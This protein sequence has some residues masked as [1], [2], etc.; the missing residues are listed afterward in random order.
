[1]ALRSRFQKGTVGARKG[2]GMLRVNQTRPHCVN[3]MGNAQAKP[4]ATRHWQRRRIV[5]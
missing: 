5:N 4:T 1:V 2:R 3:Q